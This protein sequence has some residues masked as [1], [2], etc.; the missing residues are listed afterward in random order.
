MR[1][2]THR[3]LREGTARQPELI[4]REDLIKSAPTE[5]EAFLQWGARRRREEGRFE[6]SRGRVTCNMIWTSRGHTRVCVNI[7]TELGRLL[8]RDAFDIGSADFAVQTPV[9]VRS[10]D[11]VVDR[12]NSHGRE[13]STST[14][15]FIAEVL[16]PS[17]AGKDFTEKLEEYTAID[18]LQTYLICSQD[19]PRAWVWARQG[20]GSWPR[21]PVELVGRERAI[22]VGG[23]GVDLSM[24]VIFRGIPDAPTVE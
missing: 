20:D 9:G 2:D 14:P 22:A 16:S 6:L 1:Q 17:T 8:D 12:A 11:V 24:A 7:V 21:R 5:P 13:L 10:P 4:R 3:G 18:S 15:I 19:E 23:L